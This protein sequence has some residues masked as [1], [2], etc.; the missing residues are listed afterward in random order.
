MPCSL[1]GLKTLWKV[2][3]DAD[4]EPIDYHSVR[5][6]FEGLKGRGFDVPSEASV[7]DFL[8]NA[9]R[10]RLLTRSNII[11]YQGVTS[12]RHVNSSDN[13]VEVARG[14]VDR[15]SRRRKVVQSE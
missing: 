3:F 13:L 12:I 15:H 5:G 6:V 8:R 4:D 1:G 10:R 9:Q 7:R 14:L 11:R 2:A